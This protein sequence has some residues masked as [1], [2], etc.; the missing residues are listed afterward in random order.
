MNTMV[1]AAVLA[2]TLML[3][4]VWRSRARAAARLQH[5]LDAYA[6]LQGLKASGHTKPAAR[7]SVARVVA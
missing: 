4:I 7:D 3:G 5:A 2:V 1:A 6:R